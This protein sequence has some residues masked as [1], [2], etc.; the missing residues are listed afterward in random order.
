MKVER[1]I[2]LKKI[3]NKFS[4]KICKINKNLNVFI[5]FKFRSIHDNIN[6]HKVHFDFVFIY[7]EF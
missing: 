3:T 4:I 2:I 6:S 1:I 7:Y 5:K